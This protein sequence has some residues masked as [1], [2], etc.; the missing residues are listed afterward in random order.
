VTVIADVDPVVQ[1]LRAPAVPA[2]EVLQSPDLLPAA[3]GFYGWWSHRGAITAVPHVPHPL[4]A[5]LSLLY[6]GISPAR[7]TS[8]QTIRARVIGNHLT[9]NVGS[10]TFRFVL[11]AL[12]LD[13]LDLHPYLRGTK[14]ALSAPENAR[15]SAWQ[16]EHLL[17]TWCARER[18]WEIES[19]VIAQLTP[20]LNSASNAAHAFYPA[21]RAARAEFR[22]RAR[23]ASPAPAT[24]RET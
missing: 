1:A 9:G 6:A 7:E 10:S 2:P 18:P 12:L 20:P 15:L 17:L 19:E 5:E 13:A 22:R 3:P 4:D 8:R 23:A 14:A 24:A 21:V 16:R 11:A